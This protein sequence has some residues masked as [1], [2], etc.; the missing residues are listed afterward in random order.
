VKDEAECQR[1]CPLVL[2]Q[3]GFDAER[4]MNLARRLNAGKLATTGFFR[5]ISDAEY[6]VNS[7]VANA[8]PRFR[9]ILPGFEKPG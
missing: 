2:V 4:Q 5:R 3:F 8:T 7:S 6:R 9:T 1:D